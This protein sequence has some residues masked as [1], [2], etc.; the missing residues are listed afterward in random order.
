[1]G[2]IRQIVEDLTDE[3]RKVLM[4]AFNNGLEACVEYNCGKF[5]A[6]NLG[7]PPSYLEVEEEMGR[8][9]AGKVR[10]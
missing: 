10:K 2:N 5:V 4:H 6:V 1:M 8:W 3:Q 9:S 7:S